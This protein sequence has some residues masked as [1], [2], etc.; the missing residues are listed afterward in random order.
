MKKY[1]VAFVLSH[2][3]QYFSPLFRAMDGHPQI[4]LTVYYCSDET[5]KTGR[6]I[7]FGVCVK[8]DVPLLEGYKYKFLKNHSPLATIFKPPLGL[9]NLGIGEEIKKN[10][11]AAVIIHGWNYATHWLAYFA[12]RS[13][14]TPVFI[15][16]ESPLNQEQ[17]RNK[18]KIYAKKILLGSLFKRAS[19]LLAIGTQNREFYEFYNVPGSKIFHTP[20][21]VENKRFI[22]DSVRLSLSKEDLRRK[23]GIPPDA[24][25]ILF[26]GK[27]I[28]KKRPLDLLRAY[29]KIGLENKALVYLGDGVLRSRLEEYVKKNNLKNVYF[30]G[31]KNQTEITAY[32]ALADIFV[33]PSG[34]G[35]TW[36]LVVNEAMCFGLPLVISD[37]AGCAKDLLKPGENGFVYPSGDIEAL[38]GELL[39][40]LQDAGLRRDFGIKSREII[41]SWSY[42]EDLKGILAALEYTAAGRG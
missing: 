20:Y 9:I 40:L 28:D 16:G 21:A 26:S 34:I 7:E 19:A 12:A 11:Y 3:I 35:E 33:L 25:V 2:P 31:F 17:T 5:I 6:D 41:N 23:L 42:E 39:K 4:D 30:S 27:L 8:W 29:E 37:I 10:N 13:S 14:G 32:Y 24:P 22:E 15:R 36:G 1:K 38:S 18:A